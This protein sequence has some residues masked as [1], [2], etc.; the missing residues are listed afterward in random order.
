[1]LS[2]QKKKKKKKLKLIQIAT[3]GFLRWVSQRKSD[4][5]LWWSFFFVK[6]KGVSLVIADHNLVAFTF[7]YMC[8]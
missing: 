2:L 3:K 4:P 6:L 8:T 1:M 7:S 5:T